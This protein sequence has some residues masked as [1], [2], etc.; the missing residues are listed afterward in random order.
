VVEQRGTQ[1]HILATNLSEGCLCSFH[2]NGLLMVFRPFEKASYALV[3]EVSDAPKPGD[4]PE[5][6]YHFVDR[7]G[8]LF[9][10]VGFIYH[11][12]AQLWLFWV[13]P[14]IGAALAGLAYRG[15]SA[16]GAL[17]NTGPDLR[18]PRR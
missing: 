18:A 8:Y 10:G 1:L 13:A 7:L 12:I 17:S 11:A 14:L 2:R 3:L 16:E 15:L 9:N 4:E 5:S 6:D